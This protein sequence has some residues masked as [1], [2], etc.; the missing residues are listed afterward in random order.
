[1][2]RSKI[3]L[4]AT[5]LSMLAMTF[6]F[7]IPV[8]AAPAANLDNSIVDIALAVNAQN[9]E[10]STLI[11][12]VVYT[13]LA[14]ILDGKGQFTV[15][16]PTDAAFA[17]LGLTKDNITTLDKSFVKKV[18]LYHVA[19]GERFSGDVVSSSRIRMLNKAFTTVSLPGDGSV[20]INDA[21]ILTVDIDASNGVI[22]V[23]DTVL[24]P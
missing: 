19:R 11:A 23:I 3:M 15:F 9:G 2:F 16:A 5:L 1:M 24:L 8:K 21:T 12:A 22:H 4:I 20:K 6:A 10:F 14:P 18:L 7:A 13:G 17:K